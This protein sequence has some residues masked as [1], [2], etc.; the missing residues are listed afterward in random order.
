MPL[1]S[2]RDQTSA[3]LPTFDR[4]IRSSGLYPH[5]SSVRRHISQSAAFG[6][7]SIASVTGDTARGAAGC[8]AAATPNATT[9]DTP[10]AN[11]AL[12]NRG[13]FD[14]KL[15]QVRLVLRGVVVVLLQLRPI[16][17]HRPFVEPHGRRVLR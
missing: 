4:S 11:G 17:R 10:S 14:A 7:R 8:C 9:S 12:A 3:S 6:F 13:V 15:V 1:V 16:L 2:G 5:E